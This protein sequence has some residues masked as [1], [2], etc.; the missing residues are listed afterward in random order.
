MARITVEDCIKII[1]NRFELCLIASNRAKS[2]LS[3]SVT[4]LNDKKEKPAVLALRELAEGYVNPDIQ[5]KNIVKTIKNGGVVA[6]NQ[7]ASDN[8]VE[9]IEE[10]SEPNID[11]SESNFIEQNISVED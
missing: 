7:A 9:A 11:K 3:G 10:E 8:I 2:I 1:P 6:T 4:V 5:R